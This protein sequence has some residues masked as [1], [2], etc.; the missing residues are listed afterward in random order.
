MN[1]VLPKQLDEWVE[2]AV[3]SGRFASRKDAVVEALEL[4]REQEMSDAERLA[5][6]KA[7]IQAGLDSGPPI[8]AAAVKARLRKKMARR[9]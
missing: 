1:I 5:W 9:Q 4:L 6:L 2:H 7:E 3:A 8:P